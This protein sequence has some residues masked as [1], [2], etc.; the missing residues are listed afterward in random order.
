ME[1]VL[2]IVHTLIP[3]E[4]KN[5]KEIDLRVQELLNK[6]NITETTN[7]LLE[8]LDNLLLQCNFPS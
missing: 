8:Q 3:V 6:I 2:S 1:I 4:N 7:K 5:Y